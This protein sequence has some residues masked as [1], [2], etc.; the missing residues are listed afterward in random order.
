MVVKILSSS[1]TFNGVSYNTNK[2]DKDKGELMK[3]ANFGYLEG[4]TNIQPQE[5]KNY[6]IFH[7]SA[8]TRMKDKQFHAVISCKGKEFD[9]HQLTS[10]AAEYLNRMGYGENPYLIVFH[11]DTENNHVHLVTSRIDKEGKRINRDFEGKRSSD[12]IEKILQNDIKLS[13]NKLVNS[14]FDYSI[15]TVAQFKLLFEQRGYSVSYNDR[16]MTLRKYND[17]QEII[18]MEKVNALLANSRKDNG[19]AVQ[20]KAII[21]KY[22]VRADATVNVVYEPSKYDHV[23]KPIGYSSDL[24][25]VL[26]GKFGLEI[27]YHG[28][29]GLPPYGYSIID[30]SNKNVF[31]GGEIMPLKEFMDNRLFEGR[32]QHAEPIQLT[33]DGF[34]EKEASSKIFGDRLGTVSFA[35]IPTERI[36]LIP[37]LLKSALHEFN[38]MDE[39]LSKHQIELLTDTKCLYV[40]DKSSNIM[41]DAKRVLSGSDYA[42]MA[43][44]SGLKIPQKEKE[45]ILNTDSSNAYSLKGTLKNHGSANYQ[46]DKEGK[47]SY[48]IELLKPNGNLKV[49]WGIDLERA[50]IGSGYQIGDTIQLNYKGFNEVKIRVPVKDAQGLTT[51]YEDKVVKRND[52]DVTEPDERSISNTYENGSI[53]QQVITAQDET[54]LLDV[55][56]HFELSI[57]DDIDDE[58]INGRNRRRVRKSR[59]NTR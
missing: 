56:Q 58:Q 47:P 36:A 28:K 8:N 53:N 16:E 21:N 50:L 2:T 35:A 3:V 17:V 31:K 52:W 38:S 11:N 23:K 4:F 44:R 22:K 48:F 43:K 33:V 25:S 37:V 51:H 27:I 46:F 1:S 34:K 55:I 24:A 5:Y 10:I 54:T 57:A 29:K 40:L 13:T 18:P 41:I 7:S 12:I 6:L 49:V 20:L 9:K 59:V 45:I 19:R 26:K 14:A 15:S 42:L 32:K 39:G 30:H